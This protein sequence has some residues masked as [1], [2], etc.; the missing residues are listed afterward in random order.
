MI[1]NL[2][3]DIFSKFKDFEKI[4]NSDD[5]GIFLFV[6][7]KNYL[8]GKFSK[9]YSLFSILNELI[10]LYKNIEINDEIEISEDIIEKLEVG[11]YIKNGEIFKM[12][13]SSDFQNFEIDYRIEILCGNDTAQ[14]Y[15]KNPIELDFKKIMESFKNCQLNLNPIMLNIKCNSTSI[16][17]FKDG[18]ALIKEKDISEHKARSIYEKIIFVNYFHKHFQ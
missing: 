16:I 11:T 7:G 5:V 1:K 2:N 4:K 13:P 6:N 9:N 10:E 14:V 15:I 18:K 12:K 3:F 8:L 17:L